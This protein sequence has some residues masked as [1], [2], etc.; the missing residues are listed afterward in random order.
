M[1]KPVLASD[2][3]LLETHAL[4]MI[5]NAKRGIIMGAAAESPKTAGKASKPL[6]IPAEQIRESAVGGQV[7]LYTITG[8]QKP[9][10]HFRY[11]SF[12]TWT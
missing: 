6:R 11:F 5:A 4:D 10:M 12:P 7:A 1:P 8:D 3:K 2:N 9:Q